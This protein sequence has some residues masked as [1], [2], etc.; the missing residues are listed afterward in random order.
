MWTEK[1]QMLKLDLEK[2]EESAIKLP[3]SIGSQKKQEN[4]RKTSTSASFT[5]IK[6][7]TVWITTK[8][9]KFLKRWEYQTTVPACWETSMQVKKQQLEL[10]MEQQTGS[11]LGKEYVKV[12][13]CHPAYFI[14]EYIM[15]N[16]RLGEA[17]S[18]IKIVRR[19]IHNLW[20]TND[21][22]LMAESEEELKSLLMK[23]KEESEK[24]GVKLNI[25]TMK[26]M[27]SSPITSWQIAGEIMD[28]VTNFISLGSKI[29]ADGNCIWNY[30]MLAPW[31]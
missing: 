19:N 6:P 29:T 15:W 21:T 12:V 4:S 7:L 17:Q 10:D 26:I 16:A 13:Y 23:V 14:S 1:I 28:T 8:C 18:G 2:A 24:A 30:K 20:Y 11:K 25:Q 5:T 27:A 3:T 22:T 9:G 31:E